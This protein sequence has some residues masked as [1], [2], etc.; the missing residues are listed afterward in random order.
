MTA[1]ATRAPPPSSAAPWSGPAWSL[2]SIFAA[3]RWRILATYGLFSVENLLRLAQPLVMGWAIH[4][5]LRASMLGLATLPRPARPRIWR[6]AP[7][8]GSTIRAASRASMPTSPPGWSSTSAA[9]QVEVSRVAAR[10]ALSREIV[11]FFER[12]VM[13]V[14]YCLYSV[15]GA[16][17]MLYWADSGA[18][19]VVSRLA[20]AGLPAQPVGRA[21]RA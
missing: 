16:L 1:A 4:D 13:V 8:G 21:A 19:A 15:V 10:S 12:D 3:Y 17:A 5:L 18:G 20:A 6:S 14:I 2:W 7:P 9:A 11:D